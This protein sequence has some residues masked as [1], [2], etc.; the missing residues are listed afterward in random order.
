MTPEQWIEHWKELRNM[1]LEAV[2]AGYECGVDNI[3]GGGYDSPY[4]TTAYTEFIKYLDEIE[5]VS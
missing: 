2:H 3:K 1:A 5:V 4:E